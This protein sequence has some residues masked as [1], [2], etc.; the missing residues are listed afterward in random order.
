MEWKSPSSGAACQRGERARPRDLCYARSQ[1]NK[2]KVKIKCRMGM[3][4]YKI[5]L[6]IF[7]VPSALYGYP[8]FASVLDNR[9]SNN[10]TSYW[11]FAGLDNGNDS[12][13]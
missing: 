1:N 7:S 4:E 9:G 13:N 10:V 6:F 2:K 11:I 8:T 5:T 3:K 12:G